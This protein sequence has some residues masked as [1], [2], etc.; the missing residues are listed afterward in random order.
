MID[1]PLSVPNGNLK[2]TISS[3]LQMLINRTSDVFVYIIEI[4]FEE[5]NH[6]RHGLM[7]ERE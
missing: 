5:I 1:P 6:I 3:V 7:I 2:R 4:N